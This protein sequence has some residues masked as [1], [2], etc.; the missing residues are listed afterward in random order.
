[1]YLKG[2]DAGA[3]LFPKDIDR[4]YYVNPTVTNTGLALAFYL[5]FNKVYLVGVDLA[6]PE[7]K[8]HAEGS[9]YETV[10]K[11]WQD[12]FKGEIEVEAN[13]GGTVFTNSIFYASKRDMEEG[14]KYFRT[15]RKE[16]E[17]YN[18]NFGAKIEGAET[19]Q[20][21][22]FEEH[23]EKLD[24]ENKNL[25]EFL[26]GETLIENPLTDMDLAT[27]KMQ[28]FTTFNQMKNLLLQELE[29]FENYEDI[30]NALRDIYHI[31]KLTQNH[32]YIVYNLLRGTFTHA[33]A[34][35]FK[36]YF[37]EGNRE[38]KIDFFKKAKEVIKEFLNEAE[39]ELFKLY[40]V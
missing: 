37:L 9:V 30:P 40:T 38:R 16:F 1:M 24:K 20:P 15:L 13:F 10:F 8:H 39:Q 28:I 5:G 17:V 11:D 25:A 33:L 35:L 31:I 6:F 29:R 36:A 26:F 23:L 3:E 7:E 21:A 12:I 2:A 27:K 34:H 14:I 18:P 4:L 32:N 22:E 19:L